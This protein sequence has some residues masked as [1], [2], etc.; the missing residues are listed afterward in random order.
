MEEA[1][2]QMNKGVLPVPEERP[3]DF[4]E[5]VDTSVEFD[6]EDKPA[7]HIRTPGMHRNASKIVMLISALC[8]AAAGVLLH[9]VRGFEIAPASADF[10]RVFI[11]RLLAGAAFLS[12]EY[13]L[14]FFAIGDMLVWI[15]PLWYGM[16][17]GLRAAS[18]DNF[19]LIP[20]T[21]IALAAAAFAAAASADFSQ[22][23]MRLSN[24]GTVYLEASPRQSYALKFLGFFIVMIAAALLEAL[25]VTYT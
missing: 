17:L 24:G 20:C 5:S 25:F 2:K 19:K 15:L 11:A 18:A 21:V 10:S 4:E 6:A 22:T 12:G 13:V 23:L 3:S 1:I 14:G 7:T 8:G 16:G 9:F